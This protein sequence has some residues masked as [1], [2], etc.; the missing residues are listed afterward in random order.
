MP[1]H[2]GTCVLL[3]YLYFCL[4]LCEVSNVN[5][6]VTTFSSIVILVFIS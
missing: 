1:P 3:L 2:H 5:L 6:M 4:F